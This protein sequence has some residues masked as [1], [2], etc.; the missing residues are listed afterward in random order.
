MIA[1]DLR[2]LQPLRAE[3]AEHPLYRSLGTLRELRLFMAHQV[4]AV[5][6]G[7]CL[8][9]VLQNQVAP[10]QVPWFPVGRGIARCLINQQVLESEAG[11]AP[12][13]G[14][15]LTYA[16]DFEHYCRALDQVGGD[17]ALPF[18][19][20]E[21]VRE[22]GVDRALY[23]ELVPLPA[24]YFCETTFGFIREDKPHV[25]AAALVLGRLWLVPLIARKLLEGMG[26]AE[27]EA[28][29]FH[30]YLQRLIPADGELR[31]R[32]GIELIETLCAGDPAR[33]EE[34]ENAGEEAI[35]AWIRFFDGIGEALH[36]HPAAGA[37]P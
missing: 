31:D 33:L 18:R 9:K 25:A 32:W 2:P 16:S 4:F 27:A 10:V 19:F 13:P 8:I 14:G 22:Q 23:S 20:L 6:D 30:H 11:A 7:I 1:L 12:G 5:W 3:L 37:G 36:S 26:V 28:P 29:G 35:C 24:R 15:T 17:G 21:R 34:A